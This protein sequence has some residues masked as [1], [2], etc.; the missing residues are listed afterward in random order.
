MTK[1]TKQNSVSE[2][3]SDVD[4]NKVKEWLKRDLSVAISCLNALYSDPDLL[5]HMSDFM[6]GRLLNAKQKEA[7][8]SIP[9]LKPN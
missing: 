2:L 6:Y 7:V 8:D 9:E 4:K 5:D 3:G 1:K